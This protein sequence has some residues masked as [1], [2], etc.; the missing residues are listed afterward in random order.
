MADA[1]VPMELLEAI[2]QG[3]RS[4]VNALVAGDAGLVNA[5]APSGES[6]VLLAVY[7]GHDAIATD[8]V[9]AGASMDLHESAALGL[10]ERV[11]GHLKRRPA[12]LDSYSPDG[13][14][15]LHLAAFF[16]RR[17][18]ARTLLEA[19]A[20]HDLLAGNAQ[21]NRALHA[22]TAARRRE[23][24]ELLLDYAA[25]VNALTA[26]GWTALHLAAHG[27]YLDLM[28]FLLAR[29]ARTGERNAQGKSPLDLALEQG[30]DQAAER[31][32]QV[33]SCGRS[34]RSGPR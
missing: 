18:T 22:A 11:Q 17:D 29:G 32:R 25:D 20:R 8:L 33:H 1:G 12:D 15:P 16:G 26:Q 14:T 6:A 3:D 2:R 27:G 4:R 5:R 34:R 19:G 9:Q 24:V 28:E 31:L 13:W 21:A 23:V 10:T 30:R 7:H